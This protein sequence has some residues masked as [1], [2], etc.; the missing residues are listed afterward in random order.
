MKLSQSLLVLISSGMF[1]S[2]L[3][4]AV[5]TVNFTDGGS[6]AGAASASNTAGVVPGAY[7]QTVADNATA[8]SGTVA[9]NLKD[10]SNTS[11]GV[12]ISAS[13]W[14]TGTYYSGSSGYNIPSG[15]T[16]SDKMME[17]YTQTTGGTITLTGLSAWLTA[18]GF[19]GYDVYYYSEKA[20]RG[21]AA[22]SI[23][24]GSEKYFLD[25][26]GSG[27]SAAGPF[28]LGTDT[29]L[30]AAVTN[31]NIANYVKFSG[32]TGDTFTINVAQ[33][34]GYGNLSVNGIQIVGV[35]V[36]EPSVALLGGLGFLALLRRRRA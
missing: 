25:N 20:Y 3:P 23:A 5:I 35:L 2:L 17:N 32:V 28:I 9:S 8:K 11:T 22:G 14:T 15:T 1:S 6:G 16:Q 36:P 19:T 4:A 24:I 13:G 31:R 29:T 18:T 12:A 34:G 26:G 7:I 27:A 30:A 10:N 21:E 33:D